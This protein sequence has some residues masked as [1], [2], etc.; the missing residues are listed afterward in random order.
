[1][2]VIG[3]VGL[4]GAGK[5]TAAK[6]IEEKYGYKSISYSELVHEKV[7]EEGLE[8]TRENLQM[9]AKKYREKYGMDYFAKLAVEKALNC[10]K[11]KI[12][13]KELRRKEDVEYPKRFFDNFYIIEIYANKRIRFKRLKERASKKDPK[14]WKE[15]LEQENKERELGFHEAIKYADFRIKNNRGLRELYSKI[16]KTINEIEFK[17]KISKAIEKYNKYR[18]PESNVKLEKI[19]NKHILLIFYGPFCKSCGIYDYF[20]DFIFF[21][22]DFGLDGKIKY[23]KKFDNNFLV[24]FLVKSLK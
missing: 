3:I 23:V 14:T 16:D 10:G 13:L 2:I 19:R 9:V 8:P 7:K 11:E 18:A 12:I 6:Y 5:D 1:M 24:K 22:R 20:D 17:Y 21:L 4:I 15:F